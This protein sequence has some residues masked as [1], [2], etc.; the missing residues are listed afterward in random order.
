MYK[1]MVEEM[2]EKWNKRG[3]P[4]KWQGEID[5]TL[6]GRC[7]GQCY[8]SKDGVLRFNIEMLNRHPEEREQVVAHEVAH[9]IARRAY[10]SR[11]HGEIWRSVMWTL[12][13]EPKRTHKMKVKYKHGTFEY[14]CACS[15]YRFSKVRHNKVR[16]GIGNY[17]CKKCGVKLIYKGEIES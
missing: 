12:G 17:H 4:V 11:G 13:Y 2:F 8:H 16:R 15:T 7:A 1:R 5:L 10:G 14:A 6:R 3:K 9:F